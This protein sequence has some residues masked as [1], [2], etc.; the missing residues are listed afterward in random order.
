ML[1]I[2]DLIEI[3]TE[4]WISQEKKKNRSAIGSLVNYIESKNKLRE[5]QLKAIE[6]YLWIK[7]VVNNQKL[8]DVVKQ[9]LLYDD[10]KAQEY[11][12][13]HNFKNDYVTQFIN[14]FAQDNDLKNLQDFLLNDPEGLNHDWNKILDEL[15]HDF[16]YP[17]YLY[18]LPMGA[19]K[20]Y[21]MAAFIY[22]DLYFAQINKSDNRFAHNFVVF[23]PSAS[24]TAILPS[25]QT[26]KNFDPSWVLPEQEAERLK[27]IITIEILDSLSSKRKDKLHGNNPNLEKVNRIS[28]TQNFG[29]VFITNAEKVV[30][31][32][33]DDEQKLRILTGQFLLDHKVADEIKKT[34]ELREKLSQIKHLTVILDEV[35]H[36][37][38]KNETGEKK[39]RQAV[40]I[41]NK[42]NNIV[43]V[44][45]LSG[46]PFVKS[47]V[48]IGK[49]EIKLNQIQDVV[50]NY[51]L[52]DGIGNFL[53]VPIVESLSVREKSF[54]EQ[55][56]KRFFND[57]DITYTN[58][59]KSKIVFY[60]PS[61]KV[62]NNEILPVVQEWYSKNRSEKEDEIFKYYSKVKKEDK[63]FN[64]P[65]ESLA[66][67]NNLDKPY[68]N[69][70][71]VLLVAIGTEG[72]DCKSL[73][74]VVL[75]RKQTTKNFVLQTTCRC[76]REVD[77]A[78]N[79][80][81]LI[82]LDTSNYDI[83][84]AQLKENYKLS[85]AD[86]KPQSYLDVPVIIRKPKLG[87]L[88]YNQVYK[89]FTII[90]KKESKPTDVFTN[91]NISKFKKLYP[92]ELVKKTAEIGEEGLKS[93]V[94]ET[95]EKDYLT[96]DYTL[97][98]L[99][100]DVA[101]YSYLKVSEYD[102]VTKYFDILN[103]FYNQI[104]KEN[105][106]ISNH[107]DEDIIQKIVKYVVANLMPNIE[108]KKEIIKEPVKIELLE[109]NIVSPQIFYGNGKFIPPIK[110][111]EVYRLQE[112][113][114]RITEYFEDENIDTNDIS[115]NY[116]PYKFDSDFEISAI[117]EMLKLA[118]L[119]NLE[120]YFNGYKDENLQNFVIK[121]DSG[122]Y[123][124]DFLIL[125]RTKN[126]KYKAKDNKGEI[127]KI[128]IIETKGKTYYEDFKGKENFINSTFLKHNNNFLFE[129][130][131]DKD[132]NDF[133]VHLNK[134][135]SLINKL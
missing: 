10:E 74:A 130:F 21:L 109:W 55:A 86:L 124:P 39:L 1:T 102:V 50:Y 99:I 72:W 82:F 61:I 41:L 49:S 103:K 5:P 16:D 14:Q 101:K 20:T 67:F 31:E 70:R 44:L 111:S 114:Y 112:R 110:K 52:A 128:L 69:K 107:T 34:N 95:F 15:L 97:Q 91:F 33:F 54:L 43:S 65:K 40:N 135:K 13:Y 115:F 89:K 66:V 73:T 84:N 36:T 6:V 83:L 105:K 85:I 92:Y 3:K 134:L 53:K 64:L 22:I 123:T 104:T 18:S 25:L 76:L 68:S 119:S 77:C 26:I 7:F 108:F 87:K 129:C 93:Q 79:E 58:G 118:E 113:Q 94:S 131:V 4:S 28:Q 2:F 11:K 100:Y 56:L 38:G 120:V 117:K 133:S 106:W 121:T 116:I 98:D 81:A 32:R 23:A 48:K 127:E 60:C 75:P 132:R 62:L 51:S 90:L 42:H 88:S 17:N 8:S 46:T 78:K 37:Y 122:N 126:K 12:Y 9:G 80:E 24:K 45:G 63:L 71:V 29:M 47:K 19:G 96:I 27:R 57:F 35:H 59:T 125:K 30:L